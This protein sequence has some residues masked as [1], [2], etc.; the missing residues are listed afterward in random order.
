MWSSPAALVNV[1]S[2]A[3]SMSTGRQSLFSHAAY[4]LRMVSSRFPPSPVSACALGIGGMPIA[5]ASAEAPASSIVRRDIALFLMI[6]FSLYVA[7]SFDS[8]MI[9]SSGWLFSL[10][11]QTVIQHS[12]AGGR[13][14]LR[15]LRRCPWTSPG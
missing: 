3:S 4:H 1:K 8:G 9:S 14:S 10:D 5:A 15:A 7:G 11:D 12:D 2:S 13:C 6:H